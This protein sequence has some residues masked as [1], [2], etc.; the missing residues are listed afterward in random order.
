MRCRRWVNTRDTDLMTTVD[1]QKIR[2]TRT[3]LIAYDPP[4]AQPG[5]TLFS[6]MFGD[7]T[8]YLVDMDGNVAHM[9][10]LPYRPGLF[11]HLLDNGHLLYSGK[12]IEDL[13]RFEAWP[14]IKGG[15]VL[16]VDWHGRVMWEVRHPTTTMTLGY[17]ETAT[18]SC[19]ARVSCPPSSSAAF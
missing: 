1:Q 5:F 2:R 6:P 7:G 15:A 17:S 3:G 13:D 14:R 16:E 10:R 19:C 9:W 4:R 12:V 8:V 11:G 18:S